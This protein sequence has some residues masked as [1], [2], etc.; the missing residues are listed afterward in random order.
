MTDESPSSAA[1][2]TEAKPEA[3]KA[4]N[5][6]A[7]AAI[8]GAQP[9]AVL[10]RRKRTLLYILMAGLVIGGGAWWW[11]ASGR[12]DT[13]DAQ[14]DGHVYTISPR[15]PGYV[16]EVLV[17]DNQLVEKDQP[18]VRIDRVDYEV[19]LADA[20]AAL[21]ST[22]EDSS[23]AG[24]DVQSAAADYNMAQLDLTRNLELLRSGSVSQSSVDQARTK[25][26]TAKARLLASQA[27]LA[28]FSGGGKG[29]KGA[30]ARA[31]KI[32]AQKAKV[33][34]AALNL[35]YTTIVAPARGY[36]TKKAV[37]T[38]LMVAKGQPILAIVPAEAGELWVT[39]NFKETQLTHVK[40]GQKVDFEVDTYPGKSFKGHVDSIMAGTGSSFSLFP[41]EN[42]A[43]N[44]VKVVQRVPVK[45][46]IDVDNGTAMPPLRVGM[47]VA[48]VIHLR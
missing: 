24:Q 35:E 41:P 14:I 48:P 3:P 20:V 22:E 36:V 44:Y 27:K 23:S 6:A 33:R 28:A 18:L 43:G 4:G 25:S 34:Q 15:V 38:G 37:E 9:T 5:G 29:G 46:A 32:E 31:S 17:A 30:G 8:A 1:A 16:T 12:V 47:S 7:F 21:T 10:M 39:A 13:D 26:D 40:P 42:A 11:H 19:A 45:I 2:N